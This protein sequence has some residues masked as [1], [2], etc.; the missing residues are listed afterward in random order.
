MAAAIVR[1]GREI[2]ASVVHGQA[3]VHGPYGGVVPELASRDHV[4]SVSE[5]VAGT[6]EQAGLA[7]EELDGV[8][9]T[10]GPGLIGSL[11][12]G[13]SFGKALAY[14]AGLPLVGVHHLVGHLAS[15]E[16][17][18]R[19]IRPYIGLVISG[20]HTALYRIEDAAPPALLGETRDDAVGEA[21]DKVAK[22]LG[23][24]FPGGPSLAAAAE[25]GR[26]DAVAF[27]RPMAHKS[28]LDFSFSGLKTAVALEV[29]RR[30]AL[31]ETDVADL[32][33]SFQAAAVDVLLARARRAL[34]QAGLRRIAV[35]GGVAANRHLREEMARAGEV[36][37]F[38]SLFPPMALCTDNAAMIAAAGATLLARGVR[39]GLDLNAF[40][41]VP[42]DATLFPSVVQ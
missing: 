31:S 10:A 36:D 5:V 29:E 41:R 37:G 6:L 30:G 27:P 19:E 20:G 3:Q 24:P 21:F 34:S 4:R 25:K 7:P 2:V 12:V 18:A 26:P 33:A 1:G 9:V 22:L 15:V 13:L 39:H 42:I 23:L 11:L 32:A 8:A 38:E 40:S 16:L 35:V 17:G 14:R 28:G